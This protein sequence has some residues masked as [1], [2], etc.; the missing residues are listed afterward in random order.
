MDATGL[1]IRKDIDEIYFTFKH[2]EAEDDPYFFVVVKGNYQTERIMSYLR[3][4]Q[5]ES[6]IQEKK[7]GEHSIYLIEDEE[8]A[9]C[10]AD[11]QRLIAGY[12]SSLENW[13]ERNTRDQK[14]N[15][16]KELNQSIH[17]LKYKNQ[18]WMLMDAQ[19]FVNELMDEFSHREREN[20]QGLKSIQQLN[21]SVHF[22]EKMKFHAFGQFEDSEKAG[23][24]RDALKGFIATAKLSMSEDREAIDVL[25]KIKI[26]TK[27][28]EVRIQFKMS[29]EDIDKLR[30]KRR[31][32]AAN[33]AKNLFHK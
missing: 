2:V 8:F 27:K 16:S 15:L 31:K 19:K 28:K 24:F 30:E 29:K 3:E 11:N 17:E 1:D 12:E 5:E 21:F 7:Y 18:G 23:L 9:I 20:F 22:D 33:Q 6:E 25:N 14:S 32:F 10:F 4:N 13:L 26:D